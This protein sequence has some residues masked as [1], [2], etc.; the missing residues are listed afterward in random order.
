MGA[1]TVLL[2]ITPNYNEL[3]TNDKVVLFNQTL[4]PWDKNKSNEMF[5]S[6][7]YSLIESIN[8]E[9]DEDCYCKVYPNDAQ[10]KDCSILARF[11][12]CHFQS[13]GASYPDSLQSSSDLEWEHEETVLSFMESDLFAQNTNSR[14]FWSSSPIRRRA[15]RIAG[16]V[17][18]DENDL[19][20][21]DTL[22]LLAEIDSMANSIHTAIP[23]S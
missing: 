1:A 5:D 16:G 6:N 3:G 20:D 8:S 2:V 21:V 9:L 22:Q 17:Q 18:G 7:Y 15:V 12:N 4:F 10:K 19:L 14:S 11:R 13:L 23:S